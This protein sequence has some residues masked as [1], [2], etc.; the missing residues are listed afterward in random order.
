ML[1]DLCRIGHQ[2]LIPSSP[3]SFLHSFAF[4]PDPFGFSQEH[5]DLSLFLLGKA[6]RIWLKSKRMKKKKKEERKRIEIVKETEHDVEA[7]EQSSK[8]LR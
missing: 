6:K 7:E 3:P 1:L 4:Y 8:K 5:F 2:L